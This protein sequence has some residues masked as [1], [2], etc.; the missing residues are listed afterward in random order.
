MAAKRNSRRKAGQIIKRGEGVWLVRVARGRDASGKRVYHNKTI[1]G[2]NKAAQAYLTQILQDLNNGTFVATSRKTFGEFLNEWLETVKRHAV[3]ARTLEHYR[4]DAKRYVLPVLGPRR[5]QAVQAPDIQRLYD[6]LRGR[7]ISASTVRHHVHAIIHG[8]FETAVK[9][10]LVG[11]NPCRLVELPEA[12]PVEV[13]CLDAEQSRAL[14]AA[15]ATNRHW[16][17]WLLLIS[18]GMRPGEALG[19]KWRDL[20]G[21]QVVIQRSLVRFKDH[22]WELTAPKTKKARRRISLP[23]EVVEVLSKH[24]TAQQTLR[25]A[26]GASWEEHD[27]VFTTKSGAPLDYRTT[28]RRYWKSL[29]NKAKLPR[30]RPYDLRHTSATLLL[31]AGENV[32]VVSERLGHASAAFTLDV[33]GHLLPHMQQEA[34][35][36]IRNL[37]L[38]PEANEP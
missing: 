18:T 30:I 34:A 15:A 20:V 11:S 33:Y 2:T 21:N 7:G 8:A 29:L 19:L 10:R 13:Q 9:W 1:R 38:T 6:D 16:P 14:L 35:D 32:K 3:R 27:F 23:P 28:V 12:Q 31:S 5:L 22:T 17:L 24:R 36:R 4:A 37:I 25:Q 26:A